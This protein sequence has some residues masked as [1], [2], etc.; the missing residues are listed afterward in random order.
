MSTQQRKQLLSVLAHASLEDIQRFW[1][2]SPDDF[3]YTSLR[4]PETGMVMAVGRTE[5]NGKPFNLGEVSVTR[6]ALRLDSGETGIGYVLGSDKRHVLHVALLDALG[7]REQDYIRIKRDVLEPL[8]Q[9]REQN[10]QAHQQ[11]T[12]ETKVD[13]MTMVRGEDA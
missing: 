3:E 8:Q 13:F 10:Q 5:A 9:I 7:Q 11:K 2:Y 4:E 6:C 1:Q 12:A